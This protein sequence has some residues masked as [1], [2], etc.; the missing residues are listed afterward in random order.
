MGQTSCILL[1]GLEGQC[2]AYAQW[3][4][5]DGIFLIV[6]WDTNA[7]KISIVIEHLISS[8][9][10]TMAYIIVNGGTLVTS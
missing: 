10:N 1:L 8:S 3:N 7:C 5:C 4:K 2:V 9:S 6:L